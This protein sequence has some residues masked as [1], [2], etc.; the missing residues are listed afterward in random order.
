MLL[1]DIFQ[2]VLINRFRIIVF[3]KNLL[4]FFQLI[5]QFIGEDKVGNK[6]LACQSQF[7]FKLILIRIRIR[8]INGFLSNNGYQIFEFVYVI[9]EVGYYPNLIIFRR[10]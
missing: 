3:F 1:N 9:N 5:V 4:L 8:I 7:G 10:I 2:N 6:F